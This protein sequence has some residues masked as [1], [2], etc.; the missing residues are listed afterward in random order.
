MNGLLYA[1]V[2]RLREAD[3]Q[4]QYEEEGEDGNDALER[5]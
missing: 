3:R 1:G 5:M 4:R 2:L